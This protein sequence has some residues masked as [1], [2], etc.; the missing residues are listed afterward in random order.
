MELAKSC[1]NFKN[2]YITYAFLAESLYSEHYLLAPLKHLSL[3]FPHYN[4]HL[5]TVETFSWNWLN[6]G[7]SLIEKLLHSGHFYSG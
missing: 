7:Q 4:R 5:A 2:L 1:L 3:N 6:H